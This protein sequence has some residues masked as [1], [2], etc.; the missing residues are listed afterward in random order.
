MVTA[1]RGTA[2]WAL[3]VA[4]RPCWDNIITASSAIFIAVGQ[5]VH[6]PVTRAGYTVWHQR[7]IDLAVLSWVAEHRSLLGG[8]CELDWPF[9]EALL[10]ERL[11]RRA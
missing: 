6:H 9:L 2:T 5:G 11:A 8:V 4:M 3:E 10:S 7:C 1:V